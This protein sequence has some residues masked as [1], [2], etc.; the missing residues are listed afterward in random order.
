[1]KKILV[2]V[3]AAFIATSSFSQQVNEKKLKKF[4]VGFAK[5]VE[6]N[7]AKKC[8]KFF[9]SQYVKEQ[10]DVFL[11]GRTS[12]FVS[13]FLL[14]FSEGAFN[15]S[16]EDRPSL[17][18]VSSMNFLHILRDANGNITAVFDLQLKSGKSYRLMAPISVSG[19]SGFGIV[20]AMG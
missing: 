4:C 1:M 11:E 19:S 8:L 20:G 10:H 5:A 17:D 14:G 12:Q 15:A 9:D 18:K 6:S 3:V 2:F 7:N 16:G 13:E